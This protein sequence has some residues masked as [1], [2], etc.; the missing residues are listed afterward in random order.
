MRALPGWTGSSGCLS[1][2]TT[3]TFAISRSFV[4]LRASSCEGKVGLDNVLRRF[5]I[6]SAPT[7]PDRLLTLARRAACWPRT[8]RCLYFRP[9]RRLSFKP[10]SGQCQACSSQAS[11]LSRGSLTVV[12]GVCELFD[13]CQFCVCERLFSDETLLLVVSQ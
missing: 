11:G 4:P 12:A 7:M 9:E 5:R 3:K 8:R 10:E 6:A 2:F 13:V 1:A